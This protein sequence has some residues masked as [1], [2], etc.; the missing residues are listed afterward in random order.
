MTRTTKINRLRTQAATLR[1]RA[2]E[3]QIDA[4]RLDREAD[5][6]ESDV[7]DEESAAEVVVFHFN[8]LRRMRRAH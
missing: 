8:M 2:A 6:L 4:D 1:R 3:F 5:A 7:L